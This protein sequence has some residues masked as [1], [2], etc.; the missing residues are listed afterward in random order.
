MIIKSAS[1]WEG[2]LTDK[3]NDSFSSGINLL[4]SGEN[5]AGKSTYLRLLFFGLGYAIPQTKGIDFS[6]VE[7]EIVLQGRAGEFVVKRSQ[8]VLEVTKKDT[9]TI[10][11]ALPYEHTAFLSYVL[12]Y[13]NTPVLENLLGI[14]YLDQEKGWTLLNRGTVIGRIHFS[15]EQL[16]AGLNG[17]SID[18]L[19]HQKE[20]L[21]N[22]IKKYTAL[23]NIKSL[24][25]EV[26]SSKGQV[27]LSNEEENLNNQSADLLLQIKEVESK[28][29]SI[30]SVIS[31]QKS[32]FDFVDSMGLVVVD[33]EK[34]IQVNRSNIF[35]AK[36]NS[37]YLKVRLNILSVQLDDLQR[38]RK[39]VIEDLNE[40]RE[41]T[42]QQENQLVPDDSD[43]LPQKIDAQISKVAVDQVAVQK[44]LENAQSERAKIKKEITEKIKSKDTYISK[45]YSIIGDMAPDLKIKDKLGP[46]KDFIFTDDLKS[47][48][49]A[50]LQK[51]VFAFKAAFLK[52]VQEDIGEP[53][54]FVLDSPRGR[55]LDEKNT[56]VIFECLKKVLPNTQV[57]IAS[58]YQNYPFDKIITFEGKAIE[59]R[60]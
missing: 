57:F 1:F 55:E 47:L 12:D 27:K 59:Q 19:L 46:T 58:I 50:I 21:D 49:G 11:F 40:M 41:R 33:G 6:Q 10:S 42:N 14:V 45:I 17:V 16:I 34:R 60:S 30:K 18:E 44:L 36:D 43:S 29:G 53:L 7:S 54:F 5:S 13:Y 28:I 48:S 51:M 52:V 38:K 35:L 3:A 20:K 2:K 25:D 23:L 37:D 26:L 15:I 31:K 56:E 4:F 24:Q 22:D 8:D 32:L 39:A 9:P